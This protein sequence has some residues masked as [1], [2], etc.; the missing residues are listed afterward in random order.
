MGCMRTIAGRF[1]SALTCVA[2]ALSP[3]LAF[4]ADAAS[5]PVAA[6]S[7]MS[8]SSPC[9]M[10]CDGCADGKS[11]GCML[12]CNG[13]IASIPVID[14][15]KNQET[16]GQRIVRAARAMLAGRQHQPDTPP[17]KFVLA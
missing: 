15:G 9:D 10:P 16:S 2:L 11:L 3:V 13:L 12:A 7:E 5:A 17:P 4:N 6:S 8:P 14:P 1:L